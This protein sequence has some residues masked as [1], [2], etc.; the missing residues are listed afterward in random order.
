MRSRKL[1]FARRELPLHVMMMPGLIALLIFSYVPMAGL[2]IAF[3]KFNP[4]KGL[5]GGNP[6]NGLANFD[7]ILSLPDIWRVIYNTVYISL[8][9]ISFGTLV[10]IVVAL[11]L[12][13]CRSRKL[14]RVIQ[15]GV[16]FPYFL[17]WIILSG[18]LIDIL[19]PSSGIVGSAFR[20]FGA[21]PIYFLGDNRWFPFTLIFTDIWKNFGF[22]SIVYLAAIT[23]I[24]LSL[25]EAAEID[26]AGRWK[27]TLHVTLPGM[28]MVI[29]LMMVLSLGNLFNA[30]FEQVFNLYTPQVFESGDIIDTLVYRIGLQQAQFGP[31]TAVSLLKAAVSM[32]MISVSYYVS[33]RYFDYQIF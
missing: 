8:M 3:Q 16:Y 10:P 23:S 7:F 28:R 4:A 5:F 17:S 21:E 19:S 24:D 26:G 14:K 32:A 27:Q 13:E 12:N 20:L 9:K 6:F 15:T 29:V 31:S 33:W 11:L 30:G 22:N 1:S 18:V 2:I 25:Y